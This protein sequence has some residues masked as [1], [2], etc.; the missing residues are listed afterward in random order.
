MKEENLNSKNRKKNKGKRKKGIGK[1]IF[2]G[3][4]VLMLVIAAVSAG[5]VLAVLKSAPAIDANIIAN[6]KQSGKLFDKNGEYIE[7]LSDVENRQF[8]PLSQIPKSLQE[9]VIS[10]EDE[11]FESHHGIDVK[12][13]FGAIAYD[14][15]TMSKA[16]GAS[17]ITQQLIKNT[18]LTPEKAWTRKIQEMYL[19]IKLER[20]LSKDQIL[21]AYLNTMYLGGN[22]YGVQA[23]SFYY[24]GK[25]VSE[26]SLAESAL[27][28]GLTQNPSKYWPYSKR[29]RENPENYV[30]RQ[31]LVLSK[32]L[33]LGKISNEQYTEAIGQTLEFKTKE[34]EVTT[35]YQWFVEPA[36]DQVAKDY[37]EKFGITET[38]AKQQLRTGGYKIYLTIDSKVQEKAEEI[39]NDPK[40]YPKLPKKD[41]Y[42]AI[43]A[44]DKQLIQPQGAAVIMDATTGEVRAIVGGR[45]EHP[46]RSN[47]RA[48]DTDVARQ[49]G[50]AIKPL[51]VY[52]PALDKK[53]ITPA[54]TFDDSPMP[55]DF[56]DTNDGWDPK[57]YNGKFGGLTT[58]R[59]AVKDSVNLV[60]V[61]VL[62]SM[63][64]SSSIDYLRNKFHI[65]TIETEGSVN[66]RNLSALSLGGMTHGVTPLEMT[67]AYAVFSNNGVYSEPIM[68]T[69]VVDSK[70]TVVLE[71]TSDQSRALSTEATYLMTS[72]LQTVVTKGTGT[73]AKFGKMPTGGKTGTSDEHTNGWFM[74]ITPYYS[75][76]VW[77]GHDNKNYKISG[78][79]GGTA[80]PMWREIMKVAHDGLEVKN[81]PKPESGI[82]TKEVCID[83]GKAPTELCSRDPRGTR[84]ITDEFIEGTEPVEFCDIHVEVAI[85]TSTGK[86]ATDYCPA[87]LV[88]RKVFLNKT[89]NPRSATGD[90]AY[91]VP[92]E[93]C[94]IHS[95]PQSNDNTNDS[96]TNTNTEENELNDGND[97]N[98]P[99]TGD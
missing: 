41:T 36:I 89:L 4:L 53:L 99:S 11:R 88:Q 69:K 83:S 40:Y 18:V 3:F 55:Q 58:I 84:I 61:K 85:D 67:A 64:T 8:V 78:L 51:A 91:I 25:D 57:N 44:K 7:D 33:E 81:F 68:Y 59:D 90:D 9:A 42:Y 38:E 50:S 80:A 71:K 62:K 15:K 31:K 60:A 94:P 49:P 28:A 12:R 23:A 30:N 5:I 93:K 22:A 72:M 6:M 63:G 34:A 98:Q 47:N 19:A 29:N 1:K 10:I 45:G 52:S 87:E 13:V 21:N 73:K 32:M 43:N 86:L 2:T 17:T 48:T 16:Q 82:V 14:I 95:A 54:S 37:A 66:D 74:G 39:V 46:L 56:V 65:S 70:G 27:I 97:N 35:K 96:N 77:I 75:G 76:A 20:I 92:T 26:L 24:F 79:V